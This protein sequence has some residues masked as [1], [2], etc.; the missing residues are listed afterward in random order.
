MSGGGL[1]KV[2]ILDFPLDVYRRASESFEGWRR[3]FALVALGANGAPAV[4]HRLLELA[5]EAT[6]ELRAAT[7]GPDR[8]RDDAVARGESVLPE[9]VHHVPPT[10]SGVCITLSRICDEADGYC[11]RGEG[12]L[13]LASPPE[14]VAFRRWYL[15]EF[16]AQLRGE[17]P[18]PW[19]RADQDALAADPVLRASS[20]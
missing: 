18:L 14:A 6:D 13:S 17:P 12:L 11:Q 2:T 4:P 15:G 9:L 7:A 3:E 20:T 1:Q 5:G 16:T 8:L 19:S 10:V